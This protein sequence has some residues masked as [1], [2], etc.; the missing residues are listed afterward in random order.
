MRE[1]GLAPS[2]DFTDWLPLV[3]AS[4]TSSNGIFSAKIFSDNFKWI[5][6]AYSG[7]SWPDSIASLPGFFR[8]YF[9]EPYFIAIRRRDK[10]RQGVCAYK[11]M[12][13]GVWNEAGVATLAPQKIPAL[14]RDVQQA[15]DFAFFEESDLELVYAALEVEPMWIYMEDF[16]EEP[17]SILQRVFRFC[18]EA[19]V[20]ASLVAAEINTI[21]FSDPDIAV[22]LE[23]YQQEL[24]DVRH[25][26]QR[27]F[28]TDLSEIYASPP[29]F[30]IG[31]TRRE[32]TESSKASFDLDIAIRNRL[33]EE[34]RFMGDVHGLGE[35]QLVLTTCES[36]SGSEVARVQLPPPYRLLP[37][38]VETLLYEYVPPR[39]PGTY[40]VR[41]MALQNSPGPKILAVSSVE[42]VQAGSE[43]RDVIRR[44]FDCDAPEA[45]AWYF[46][47]WF[48]Y[49]YAERYPIIMSKAHGW[50]RVESVDSTSSDACSS[51]ILFRD[52]KLAEWRTSAAGYPT[53]QIVGGPMMNYVQTLGNMRRFI[54]DSGET[55]NIPVCD[56]AT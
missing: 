11:A 9:P 17:S 28:L 38:Q 34:V 55:V 7:K 22:L 15:V 3:I 25:R 14:H 54:L 44:V 47:P 23:R 32:A 56:D 27:V 48:G 12:Q 21:S 40:G 20:E 46:S 2:L 39:L 16:V 33:R 4:G 52:C 8:Q 43:A 49:F 18:D 19:E 24:H 31:L 1:Q 6:E 5:S 10:F 37:G 51:T 50:L 13:T 53:I 30:T 45:D 29:V 41:V 35:I 42:Q 36:E 26:P